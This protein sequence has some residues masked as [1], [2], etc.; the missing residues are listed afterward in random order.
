MDSHFRIR[1]LIVEDD[2]MTQAGLRYFMEGNPQLQLVSLAP[3]GEKAIEF[4]GQSEPDVVVM[5]MHLPGI[6]GVATTAAIKRRYPRVQVVAL[7]G[8]DDRDLM[9]RAY[10]AGVH[11]YVLK[12][13]PAHD[14]V[15]AIRTAYVPRAPQARPA[16]SA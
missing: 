10:E 14:L 12:T 15:D 1:V 8:S 3:S 6:D 16:D 11:S 13:S 5:D 2:P 9:A 7:S 4:C